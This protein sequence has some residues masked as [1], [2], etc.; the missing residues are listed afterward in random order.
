MTDTVTQTISPE[1]ILQTGL[2]FW[3]SKALLSAVELELFTRL[4]SRPSTADDLRAQLALHPRAALFFS[5]RSWR[6]DS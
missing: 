3:A 4:S 2:A 5:M 6:S 1:H